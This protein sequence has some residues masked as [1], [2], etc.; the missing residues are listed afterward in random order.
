MNRER[1]LD[2]K[3]LDLCLQEVA[4]GDN[5]AF[6]KLYKDT[7][8]GIFAFIYGFCENY[9]TAEDLTQT[10]YLKVKANISKYNAGTDARAWLFQIAKYTTLNE[11]KKIKREVVASDEQTG[12]FE[13]K[14]YEMQDSPV[15]DAINSVL[16]AKERQIVIMHVLW[17]FKHREIADMLSL[18]LG[19]VLWKYNVAIKKLQTK[20][21]EG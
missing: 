2:K 4:K 1:D 17:G 7:V 12:R 10:V 3:E 11:I 16:D 14:S 5:S 8:K 19:T 15:F 6:E 18:A 21:R 9:H 20:L 13:A